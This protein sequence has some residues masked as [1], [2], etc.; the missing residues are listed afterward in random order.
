MNG[1]TDAWSLVTRRE[2]KIM[3][4]QGMAYWLKECFL[5]LGNKFNLTLKGMKCTLEEKVWP[6]IKR[7]YI[8]TQRI[9]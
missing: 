4:Q 1:I 8:S 3:L 5:R 6:T 9:M 7:K 2:I